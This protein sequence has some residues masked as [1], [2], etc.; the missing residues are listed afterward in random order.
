MGT[1][2]RR[3]PGVGG[4][5][6]LRILPPPGATTTLDIALT[7]LVR[8][9]ISRRSMLPTLAS[10]ASIATNWVMCT[11]TVHGGSTQASQGHPPE[12][13]LH[14]RRVHPQGSV[15]S[16][17]GK[18]LTVKLILLPPPFKGMHRLPMCLTSPTPTLMRQHTTTIT[19]MT[20]TVT[21]TTSNRHRRTTATLIISI[22][23]RHRYSTR[24]RRITTTTLNTSNRRRHRRPSSLPPS[25]PRSLPLRLLPERLHLPR[26]N[27]IF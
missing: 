20:T 23:R 25:M 15:D 12:P 1:V 16:R 10:D 21:T 13:H 2:V 11:N 8:L 24:S 6:G 14:V 27:Y 22:C 17:H 3:R 18:T 9:A 26:A 19:T 5:V 4:E 7:F